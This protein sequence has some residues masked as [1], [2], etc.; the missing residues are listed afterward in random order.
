MPNTFFKLSTEVVFIYVLGWGTLIL[1]RVSS[2]ISPKHTKP[3]FRLQLYGEPRTIFA[4]KTTFV[5]IY[6]L[7]V[8]FISLKLCSLLVFP[9]CIPCTFPTSKYISLHAKKWNTCCNN[10]QSERPISDGPFACFLTALGPQTISPHV[11]AGDRNILSRPTLYVKSSSL[12][13]FFYSI[14]YLCQA[15]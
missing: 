5:C 13:I 12:K 7:G 2:F 3:S 6:F 10:V 14:Q 1:P 11:A 4:T 9:H 15:F 8:F